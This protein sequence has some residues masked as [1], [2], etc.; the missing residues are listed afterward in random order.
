MPHIILEH[1]DNL[2]LPEDS[3][4]LLLELHG[5][6]NDIGGIAIGNCKSRIYT[7]DNFAIGDGT[8]TEGF[9]HLHIEF[10]SGRS[11]TIKADISLACLDILKA[12]FLPLVEFPV[13][14]TVNITDIPKSIYSKYP[15]GTLSYR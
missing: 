6:L 8:A 1:S 12:R 4:S 11:E 9:V 3:K 13:Q 5:V 2:P 15:E 7:A 14:I 10:V